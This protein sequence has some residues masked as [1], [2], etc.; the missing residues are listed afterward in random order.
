MPHFDAMIKQ[1]QLLRQKLLQNQA[2]VNLLVNTGNNVA[3]FSNVKTGSKSPAAEL[4]KTHFYVP[5]TANVDRNYI[6]MRSRVIF[7]DNNVVKETGITVY[8]ICNEHQIDLLQGS[9]ADLLADEIDRILNNGDDPL[10]GMGGITLRPAD[11]VQFNDGYSGWQIPYVTHEMN[12]RA[13]L[14]G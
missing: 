5:S 10:F 4:V 6:T 7:A 14:I 2:V 3:E 8:V 9:R 1:K 11:E 12:R 13:D